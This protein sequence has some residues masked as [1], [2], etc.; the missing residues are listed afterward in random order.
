MLETKP[1]IIFFNSRGKGFCPSAK[2]KVAF[3]DCMI[4][5]Y[6]K[7]DGVLGVSLK[8]IKCGYTQEDRDAKKAS[9]TDNC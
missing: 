5:S 3:V 4:C 2:E 6:N 1:K 7:G 9:N 8:N